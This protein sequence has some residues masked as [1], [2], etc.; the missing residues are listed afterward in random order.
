MVCI[1]RGE[2]R[3][4]RMPAPA[5]ITPVS[6]ATRRPLGGDGAAASTA[7]RAG[8]STASGYP[9]GMP[10]ARA[11]AGH[12]GRRR[13][14]PLSALPAA[15]LPPTGGA[16]G[17]HQHRDTNQVERVI[18]EANTQVTRDCWLPSE[19]RGLTSELRVAA[20]LQVAPDGRIS[21]VA[22]GT[23]PAQY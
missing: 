5:G 20:Q 10:A 6:I 9:F 3:T 7:T 12:L 4:R 21:D 15:S 22:I 14:L 17:L 16:S 11:R 19:E 2:R 8:A 13:S 23:I 18:T 1:E